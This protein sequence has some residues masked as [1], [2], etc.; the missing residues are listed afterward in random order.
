MPAMPA[1]R[2]GEASESRDAAASAER[3]VVDG[4]TW[5]AAHGLPAR[6]GVTIDNAGC[7]AVVVGAPPREA[8]L[9]AG[10]GPSWGLPSGESEFSQTILDVS[11]GHLRTLLAV[12]TTGGPLD[13]DLPD[14]DV[15]GDAGESFADALARSLYIQLDTHLASDGLTF[16]V[17]ESTRAGLGC[18][19]KRREYQTYLDEVSRDGGSASDRAIYQV[20]LQIIA[21]V[22][23]GIGVYRWDHGRFVRQ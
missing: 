11:H 12:R 20:P 2:S 9:C 6:D 7:S 22:C 23:A 14:S 19:D 1:A 10:S 13:I 8:L 17:S 4:A 21:R 5:A 16:T 18:L 3:I 15:T